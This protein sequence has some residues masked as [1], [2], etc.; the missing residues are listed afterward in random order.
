M[1]KVLILGFLSFVII[2]CSNYE[3]WELSKFH[4]VENALKD[5]EDIKV[6]YSSRGPDYN[7]DLEYY[8]QVVVV[9]QLSGDTVNILTTA[10]NGFEKEDENKVFVFYNEDNILTKLAQTY[11]STKDTGNLENI[12]LKDI[13]KVARDPKFDFIADNNFPTIVGIIGLKSLPK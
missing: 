5:G 3:Y 12:E 13:Q 1:R 10:R 7:K 8:T 11:L 2:S 6:V 4:F 9:S